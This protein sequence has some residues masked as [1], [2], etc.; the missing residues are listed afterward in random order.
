MKSLLCGILNLA[1]LWNFGFTSALGDLAATM[2]PGQWMPLNTKV[3]KNQTLIEF[4]STPSPTIIRYAGNAGWDPNSRE[5]L[6]L[7]T[8]HWEAKKGWK[9]IRY[10]DETN[11]WTSGPLPPGCIGNGTCIGHGYDHNT[12]DPV[13]GDLYHRRHNGSDVY[14][15]D[16]LTDKWVEIPNMP[17]RSTCCGALSYFPELE[18]LVYVGG[19]NLFYYSKQLDKWEVLS[20]PAGLRSYHNVSEYNPVHQVVLFGGGNGVYDLYLLDQN[21]KI[22]KIKN[23]PITLRCTQAN[24]L[25]LD[26]VSG[27]FIAI[28]LSNGGGRRMWEMDLATDSAWHSLPITAPFG[29]PTI[30]APVSNYGVTMFLNENGSKTGTYLYKHSVSVVATEKSSKITTPGV[31]LQLLPNPFSSGTKNRIK[32]IVSNL[33]NAS[34]LDEFLDLRIYNTQGKLVK[35]LKTKNHKKEASFFWSPQNLPGGLYFVKVRAGKEVITKRLI[36]LR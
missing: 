33:K 22:T 18:G 23:S 7:G 13:N 34:P 14:K 4:I 10:N 15:Y 30:S 20:S 6:F 16:I 19:N 25:T 32:F 17:A 26:P 12:V 36:Y 1:L 11:T 29:G 2:K 3:E 9:L 21:K 5:F 8:P 35:K 31:S 27:K 24:H 28:D